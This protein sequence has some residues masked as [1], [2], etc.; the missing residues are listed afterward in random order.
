MATLTVQS[1]NGTS[2]VSV[3]TQAAD[4]AGDEFVN[5]NGRTNFEV[6][7][8]SGSSIDVTIITQTTVDGLA[9]ADRVISVGAGERF[10]V[11]KLASGTYNDSDG[12]V[13]VTYS[14][15]TSVTVAAWK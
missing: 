14:A 8:G 6:N 13:Q 7:N 2:G 1:L 10:I 11:N 9:V 4:V 12:N 15:V 3:T 5:E